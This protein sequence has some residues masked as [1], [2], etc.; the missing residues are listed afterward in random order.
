MG[1][2]VIRDPLSNVRELYTN[3]VMVLSEFLRHRFMIG[4]FFGI[5]LLGVVPFDSGKSSNS[6]FPN[7]NNDT[8]AVASPVSTGDR[9]VAGPRTHL[10]PPGLHVDLARQ[11]CILQPLGRVAETPHEGGHPGLA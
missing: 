4:I 3:P 2:V 1:L 11:V 10:L 5:G 7:P 9:S 6:F 8:V